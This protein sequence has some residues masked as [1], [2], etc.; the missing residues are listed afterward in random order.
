MPGSLSAVIYIA[1][2]HR[3]L[4]PEGV[5]SASTGVLLGRIPQRQSGEVIHKSAR[6][7]SPLASKVAVA[8]S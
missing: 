7:S 3:P 4:E 6:D 1:K 5:F 2:L 8:S